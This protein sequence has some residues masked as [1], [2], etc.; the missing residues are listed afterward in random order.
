MPEPNIEDSL[1]PEEIPAA[2]EEPEEE[3]P[4]DF[5]EMLK[6]ANL[7]L[8]KADQELYEETHSEVRVAIITYHFFLSSTHYIRLE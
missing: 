3:L 6:T 8:N 5:I 2:E 1:Q 7:T 4:E